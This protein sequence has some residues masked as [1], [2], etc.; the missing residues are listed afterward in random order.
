M[1]F[2]LFENKNSEFGIIIAGY[3]LMTFIM[4]MATVVYSIYY[5]D[6]SSTTIKGFLIFSER[7]ANMI[8]FIPLVICATLGILDGISCISRGYTIEGMLFVT[9]SIVLVTVGGSPFAFAFAIIYGLIALMAYKEGVLDIM[10][11]SLLMGVLSFI[12]YF[13]VFETGSI[14]VLIL[15]VLSL[16][17]TLISVYLT[18]VA[19]SLSKEYNDLWDSFDGYN[20]DGDCDAC[21]RCDDCCACEIDGCECACHEDKECDKDSCACPCHE[22]DCR[23]H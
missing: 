18:Y 21:N 22:G 8:M 7:S 16:A 10:A 4:M 19:W 11:L 15:A 5:M 2:T 3:A 1:A 12:N 20:C 9:T 13:F 23:K 6:F 14:L 17:V